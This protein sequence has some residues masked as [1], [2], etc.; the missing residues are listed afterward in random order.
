MPWIEFYDREAAAISYVRSSRGRYLQET[1]FD[2]GIF[3]VTERRVLGATGF[4]LGGAGFEPA[5]QAEIG[6]WIRVDEAG[7]GLGSAVLAR[8]LSW[9]FSSWGFQRLTWRCDTQNVSSRRCAER[10][11]MRREGTLRGEYDP[12]SGGR[13]D[14]AC[15]GSVPADVFGD[16]GPG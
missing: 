14:T 1:D 3:D 4:H 15:Y 2:L 9:G 10:A 8:L 7:R 13:R 11:G 5:K 16:Q 12:A 6:M